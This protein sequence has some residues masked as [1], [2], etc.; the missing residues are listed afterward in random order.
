MEYVFLTSGLIY[1]AHRK[2]FI[3]I[4]KLPIICKLHIIQQQYY[5]E[6]TKLIQVLKTINMLLKNI[7]PR[8]YI[9]S[10]MCYMKYIS[11]KQE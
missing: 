2:K 5:A 3:N 1:M 7:M 11:M 9:E 8:L 10:M 6:S 4:T